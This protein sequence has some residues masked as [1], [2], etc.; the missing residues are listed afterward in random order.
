MEI[1][2]K[3]SKFWYLEDNKNNKKWIFENESDAV[4]KVKELMNKSTLAEKINLQV[5]NCGS[6]NL[7][8]KPVPWTKIANELAKK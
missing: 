6:D 4:K 2:I 7:E 3:Q 1:E 8:L 5:M